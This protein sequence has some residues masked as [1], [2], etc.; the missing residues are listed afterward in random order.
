MKK[1]GQADLMCFLVHVYLTE[2]TSL[3]DNE[4]KKQIEDK[5]CSEIM[6]KYLSAMD[7]EVGK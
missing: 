5:C 1:Y 7:M 4:E 2:N 3:A 6:K